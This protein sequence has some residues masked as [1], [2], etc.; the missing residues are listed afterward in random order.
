[1]KRL[2]SVGLM[3]LVS[4]A[5]AANVVGIEPYISKMI[6]SPEKTGASCITSKTGK[7][8]YW[9]ETKYFGSVEGVFKSKTF[10]TLIF[11][12]PKFELIDLG[13]GGNTGTAYW[14]IS[15]G[16]LKTNFVQEPKLRIGRQ[17]NLKSA[18]AYADFKK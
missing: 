9:A 7:S 8:C 17:I 18:L 3:A 1:M 2:L 13:I 11:S 10:Y 6:A 5:G 16:P 12:E 4:T 15:D 14:R